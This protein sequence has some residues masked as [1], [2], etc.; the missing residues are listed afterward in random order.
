VRL[1]ERSLAEHLSDLQRLRRSTARCERAPQ[2][3]VRAL[4]ARSALRGGRVA[5]QLGAGSVLRDSMRRAVRAA[6]GVKAAAAA[7]GCCGCC[8]ALPR[9]R[10]RLVAAPARQV[11]VRQRGSLLR[12]QRAPRALRCAAVVVVAAAAAAVA[13]VV[14]LVVGRI[15]VILLLLVV[16]LAAQRLHP[17]RCDGGRRA[18][19]E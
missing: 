2:T 12:R 17:R 5:A 1:A 9:L 8:A 7:G 15:H 11:A 10:T 6:G 13:A 4:G 14:L 16:P 3:G 19:R 18:R